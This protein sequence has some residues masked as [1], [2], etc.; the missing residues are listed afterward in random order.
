MAMIS[1]D[2]FA[3][4]KKMRDSGVLSKSGMHIFILTGIIMFGLTLAAYVMQYLQVEDVYEDDDTYKMIH[5]KRT[6]SLSLAIIIIHSAVG[7]FVAVDTWKFSGKSIFLQ[8]LIIG[9]GSFNT[10]LQTLILTLA[11]FF[12][13]HYFFAYALSALAFA[14]LANAMMIALLFAMFHTGVSEAGKDSTASSN[15]SN[16][17]KLAF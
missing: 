9:G 12:D 10:F 4:L 7:F 14:C 17:G 16:I 8:S 13:S 3:F 2:K 15:T 6:K 11:F 1:F 5:E